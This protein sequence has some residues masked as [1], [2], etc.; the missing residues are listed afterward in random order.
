MTEERG[1]STLTLLTLHPHTGTVRTF[2]VGD[3]V[4]GIFGRNG[5][6]MIANEQQREF[7]MPFQVFG[8]KS[9]FVDSYTQDNVRPS[10]IFKGEYNQFSLF[11]V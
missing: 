6:T 9:N 1:S 11:E 2:H 10:D 3:S 5:S 8:G 7:D 4:Y